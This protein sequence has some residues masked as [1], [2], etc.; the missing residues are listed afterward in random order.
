[1]INQDIVA[2]DGSFTDYNAHAMV[3]HEATT[4]FGS[5]VNF[6]ACNGSASISV[7]SRYGF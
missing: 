1:V 4:D 7:H 3:N 6:N 2:N 5:R